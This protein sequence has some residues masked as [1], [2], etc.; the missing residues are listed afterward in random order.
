L[1]RDFARE[2]NG[3]YPSNMD[4]RSNRAF[5]RS[6]M[7][8]VAR[9]SSL[10]LVCLPVMAGCA[11]NPYA[12]QSQNQAM[13]QQQ[14]ALAQRNQE[15]QSRAAT[16]DR[17]NQEL[18]TLLAQTRQQA[19]VLDDHLAA[20]RDQLSTATAQLAQLRD[21][22]QLTEKQTEALMASTRR[23]SGAQITANNSLQRNLPPLN[24]SG[25]DVRADGDVVRVELPAA[26]LFQNGYNTLQPV[27]GPLL[28]TVAAEIARAYPD[29]RIGVEGHAD[30]E[31]RY[32][33]GGDAQQISVARATAVYQ[34]LISRGQIPATRL[35]IVGH[36]N[37]HPVV[38]SATAAGKARNSRVELVVYPDKVVPGR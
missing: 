15:L 11:S 20:L 35:F 29:Q 10:V 25:I 13:Q 4:V 5:R 38:S 12:L 21:E 34:Y 17:D 33:Q 3:A 36:G 37:N 7:R 22:K 27:A 30:S 18:E 16:L 24:L 1:R 23:R 14:T 32:P 9:T 31:V 2:V 28:E 19:K 8:V 6:C 26:R